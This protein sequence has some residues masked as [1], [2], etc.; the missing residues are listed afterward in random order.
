MFDT[1]NSENNIFNPDNNFSNP[2]VETV[3]DFYGFDVN[4]DSNQSA[5][6]L[7]GT[8]GADGFT[9]D[10][11]YDVTVISGNGNVDFSTG[12]YDTINLSHISVDEVIDYSLAQATEGGVAF[13]PG[14]GARM[15]DYIALADGTEVM[16]EG[17]DGIIFSDHFEDLSVSPDDFLFAEQWNLHIMGVQNAW[18]FNQGSDNVLIGVQDTGIGISANGDFHPDIRQDET[19]YFNGNNLGLNAN[20]ADNFLSEAGIYSQTQLTSHGT[21]VQGI[22]AA[23]SNNGLGIAGINWNSDVY[24]IDVLENNPGDLSIAQAT[25]EMIDFADSNGQNLVI[26]LSIQTS[27]TF[28]NLAGIHNEFA[29]VVAD[30]PDVL[31]VVAAGNYGN[32]G[33]EGLSSPGVLAQEY[34]NVIA[35]GAAWG[36]NDRFGNQTTPGERIEYADWGSQYGDGLTVTAPSEVWTTDACSDGT[37]DYGSQFDGTS[38]AASNVTGVASLVWSANPDLTAAQVQVIL[39]ETAYDTGVEGYDIYNGHGLINA[40]A[41]VRK[42]I[43]MGNNNV[44]FTIV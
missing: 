30:N 12:L 16:F 43:A 36:T 20:L 28:G 22:I 4:Q 1:I 23:D 18:R 14:N 21:S 13:D 44:A 2:S 41:A 40:D 17:I 39:S 27:N 5:I 10:T 42:A 6:Y 8:L 7:A 26:N 32:E 9:V 24:H 15:F 35:V 3:N 31:F 19:W 37:F 38:A 25:Q 29:G 11:N 34:D 33:L